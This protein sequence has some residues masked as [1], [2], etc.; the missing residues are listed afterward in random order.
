MRIGVIAS[1]GASAA[2]GVGALVVA[3]LWLPNA[4]A[5]PA[6]AQAAVEAGVPVVVAAGAIPYGTKLEAKQLR[7]ISLPASAA[8]QG[9]YHSIA[10]VMAQDSGGAPVAL[11]A[12][13]AKE[14]VLAAK[15]SGSGARPTL[16][17]QIG[18]GMRAYTIGVS[19][20][21]GGGG[22]I[23]PGDRVDVVLTRDISSQLAPDLVRGQRMVT[24]VVL[25][26]VRVL[27]M[28]L[29]ADPNSTQAAVAHTTT[30]EVDMLDAGKLALAAQTGTLSLALRR[31]GSAEIEAVR[32]VLTSDLGRSVNVGPAVRVARAVPARRR[33][34]ASAAG[35]G[36]S[37]VV[38]HGETASTIKVPTEF[39]GV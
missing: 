37:I 14:P 21:A 9:A 20:V 3:K 7:L 4:N 31:T 30:L 38:V 34:P 16:A 5:G 17:A 26:N 25:Q 11:T 19:E 29:N 1:L 39:G 35:G 12:M 13:S 24:D 23:L 15:L 33:A 27:G 36:G 2:L 8:P 28:D 10:Q 22:H 32:P 6:K 18:P